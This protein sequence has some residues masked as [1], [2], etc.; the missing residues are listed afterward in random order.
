MCVCFIFVLF[1][2]MHNFKYCSYIW[3]GLF[4]P[5]VCRFVIY[6][7]AW[8]KRFGEGREDFEDNARPARLSTSIPDEN[9]ELLITNSY[10][11]ATPSI[12]STIYKFYAIYMRRSGEN[13]L[14]F[15]KTTSGF[16]TMTTHR[17]TPRYSS[18][19]SLQSTKPL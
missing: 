12:K 1:Y 5:L 6:M 18:N 3:N 15:G 7:Q 2:I 10:Q 8:Y 11:Q 13:D 9:A 14:N 4:I 16:C 19:N 17:Q